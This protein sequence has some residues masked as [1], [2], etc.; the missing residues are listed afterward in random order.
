MSNSDQLNMGTINFY[1]RFS[2]YTDAQILE[3]LKNQKFYQESAKNAAVKIA[4]ERQLIHSETD[5]LSPEYQNIRSTRL[6]LF[7]QIT[8]TYHY[9]KLL[10]STFRFLYVLA[11]LPIAY[12]FLKYSEGFI[13]QTILGV[14]IG[15]IWV[16]L[17]FLLQ[18][19]RKTIILAPLFGILIFV[20]V[21]VG[22][23]LA[24]NHPVR[25]FDFAVLIIGVLLSAYFLMTVKN[26]FQNKPDSI[27]S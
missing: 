14:S 9:Q 24:A 2:N 17:I 21:S 10:G 13:D 8:D 15:V 23:K 20:G 11:F 19:T 26:L 27:E 18:K 6:T 7:P 5:L 3:V 25:I 1:E 12:G 4:I 22:F 16:L